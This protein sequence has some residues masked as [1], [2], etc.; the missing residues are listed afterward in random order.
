[1]RATAL[2]LALGCLAPSAA[3][4]GTDGPAGPAV[5]ALVFE[6]ADGS[7]IQFAGEPRVWCGAWEPGN[8]PDRAVHVLAGDFRNGGPVWQ[9][10]AVV[11]DA[12]PGR[13]LTFPNSFVWDQP[14]GAAIFVLDEPNELSTQTGDSDG[15]ITF[16][17]L[18]CG[19]GGEVRFTI[20][21]TIGSEF[22][23]GPP[24]RV[25]GSFAAPVGEAPRLE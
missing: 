6:R 4:D 11:D 5:N 10:Q 12:Q 24:V 7:R 21:A 16:S 25:T 1:M 2:L 9:L 20:D 17:E 13:P 18:D 3:C 22:G 14:R 23:D 19:S 15:S 8:V